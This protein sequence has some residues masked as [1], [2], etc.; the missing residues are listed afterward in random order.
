M[1]LAIRNYYTIWRV[2]RVQWVI[3]PKL[4]FK[5]TLSDIGKDLEI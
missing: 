5:S 2:P 1:I 4:L 3:E